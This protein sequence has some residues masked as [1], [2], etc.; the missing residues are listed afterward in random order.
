ML[1]EEIY[2]QINESPTKGNLQRSFKPQSMFLEDQEVKRNTKQHTL[3]H[4]QRSE[5]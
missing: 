5:F 4:L 2:H 3:G 1:S